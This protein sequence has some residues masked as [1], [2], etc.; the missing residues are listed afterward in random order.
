MK[1]INCYVKGPK[2]DG[3]YFSY[4]FPMMPGQ[5]RSKSWSV[6]SKVYKVGKLGGKKLL[7]EIE[8]EDEGQ[9]VTLYQKNYNLFSN[10][11]CFSC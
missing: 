5:S 4:G 10:T 9:V 6:G 8:A 1:R 11:F 7:T 3:S 2:P